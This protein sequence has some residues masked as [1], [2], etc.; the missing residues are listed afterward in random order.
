[1]AGYGFAGGYAATGRGILAVRGDISYCVLGLV[2]PHSTCRLRRSRSQRESIREDLS[3]AEN[4][5]RRRDQANSSEK[6]AAAAFSIRYS[7]LRITGWQ[8]SV[9]E[10]P[11]RVEAIVSPFSFYKV[12]IP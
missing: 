6:N 4:R 3:P 10:L 2:F 1:M 8:W 5:G 9:A 11:V 7:T 12:P